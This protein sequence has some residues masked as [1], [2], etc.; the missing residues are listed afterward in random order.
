MQIVINR[1]RSAPMRSHSSFDSEEVQL[2]QAKRHTGFL[3][4]E[5]RERRE[6]GEDETEVVPSLSRR[7]AEKRR[8]LVLKSLNCCQ[9]EEGGLIGVLTVS[10]WL[11]CR[12]ARGF[13]CF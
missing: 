12:Q 9:R 2:N 5:R 6:R 10:G 1:L 13:G 4:G 8:R 3:P 11:L 7:G